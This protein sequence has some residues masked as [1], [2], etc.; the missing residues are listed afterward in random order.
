ML[1]NEF[2]GGKKIIVLISGFL[3]SLAIITISDKA[4]LFTNT[5][6]RKDRPKKNLHNLLFFIILFCNVLNSKCFI[7]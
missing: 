2:T 4:Q 1:I 5:M 6:M 3:H 7:D